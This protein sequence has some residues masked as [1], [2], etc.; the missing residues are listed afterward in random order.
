MDIVNIKT[1]IYYY[2]L[3]FVFK[4]GE[5][6]STFFD[7]LTNLSVTRARIRYQYFGERYV[8]IQGVSNG[9]N[10]IQ[11][12]LRSIR[13]DIFP[14]LINMT[15]DEVTDLEDRGSDGIMDTS[16][17]IIDFRRNKTILALEYNH[18]G[19]KIDDFVKYIEKIGISKELITKL[20]FQFLTEESFE[21]LESRINRISE[22]SLK[23]HKDNFEEIRGMDGNILQAAEA[24]INNFENEYAVLNFKMDYRKFSDTP[25]IKRSI[26]NIVH[27]FEENPDKRNLF[28]YLNFVAEDETNN[29]KLRLYDL[30]VSKVKS[31]F[32]VQKK[33]KAKTIISEDMFPKMLREIDI[34]GF[35]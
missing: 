20:G 34:K 32:N 22:F 15:N 31:E 17:F 11:G 5:N 21:D 28:N 23:I 4:T 29:N 26:L 24:T 13:D 19:A 14:Q 35:R 2:E 18:S 10:I 27:W 33:K 9:G 7:T 6:L 30:I 3:N 16:H 25:Q 8:F 1:K 12:K